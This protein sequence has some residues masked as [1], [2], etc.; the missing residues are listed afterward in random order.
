LLDNKL[1][2]FKMANFAGDSQPLAY[3]LAI[4]IF[5]FAT[6]LRIALDPFILPPAPFFTYYPTVLLVAFF[7]GLWP[8]IFASL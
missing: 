3:G 2:F 4:T 8:A 1:H 5:L 6:I 7:C